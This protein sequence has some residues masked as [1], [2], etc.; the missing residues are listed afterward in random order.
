ML[1][2]NGHLYQKLKKS[3]KDGTQPWRCRDYRLKGK[4]CK[5]LCY[6][7]EEKIIRINGHHIHEIVEK[8][9]AIFACTKNLVKKK[10]KTQ[11]GP[12][13]KIFDEEITKTIVENKIEIPNAAEFVPKFKNIQKTL[14]N[15][16]LENVMPNLPKT[17]QE[18]YFSEPY[19]KY[20]FTSNEKRFLLF[21][22]KDDDRIIAFASDIQLEIL[23]RS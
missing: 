14:Y 3:N 16:R 7:R 6:T 2:Y 9:E 21:D 17:V 23:S 8:H 22:T 13:Q 10:V 4:N 5:V 18:I 20:T 19:T 12:V 1:Y 15:I 11:T